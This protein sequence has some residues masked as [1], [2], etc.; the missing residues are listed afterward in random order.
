[1]NE[2]NKC[3]NDLP[4]HI[5]ISQFCEKLKINTGFS[6]ALKSKPWQSPKPNLNAMPVCLTRTG[7]HLLYRIYASMPDQ[8][9]VLSWYQILPNLPSECMPEPFYTEFLISKSSTCTI[10]NAHKP[11]TNIKNEGIKSREFLQ[12]LNLCT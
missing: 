4:D 6:T 12:F 7:M 1:M 3:G 2:R 5:K 8:S 10:I 9:Q 11:G